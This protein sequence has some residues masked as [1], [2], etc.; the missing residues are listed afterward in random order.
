[1]NLEN[2]KTPKPHVFVWKFT[3]KLDLRIRKKF[4][5]RNKSLKKYRIA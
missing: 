4:I 2:R 3:N 1:M 5:G